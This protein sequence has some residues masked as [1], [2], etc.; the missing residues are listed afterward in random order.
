MRLDPIRSLGLKITEIT[1][2]ARATH[3]E[4]FRKI[5]GKTSTR[6]DI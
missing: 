3:C 1:P 2:A 4:F 5:A 6:T